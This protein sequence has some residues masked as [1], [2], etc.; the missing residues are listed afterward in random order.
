MNFDAFG[1]RSLKSKVVLVTLCIFAVCVALA[2]T[3]ISARMYTDL[4]GVLGEQQ[5][6]TVEMA[7]ASMD[8]NFK[9]RFGALQSIAKSVD[10]STLDKPTSV[11]KLLEDRP[12]LQSYFNAGVFVTRRDGTAIAELPLIGRVGGNYMDRDHVAA[13]LTQGKATVGKAVVGKAVRA[14][15]FAMTVPIRDTQGKVIGALVGATDLSRPNFMDSVN[16]ARYGLAGGYLVVDPTHRLFVTATNRNLV[17]ASLPVTGINTV[18]DR[19]VQG[20]DGAAVNVNS[21]GVEVLTSSARIPTAG[22][23]L[24]ATLPT[25]EAFAPI[26]AMQRNVLQ[27]M[28]LFAALSCAVL[29]LVLS[30]ML[31][32]QFAQMVDATRSIEALSAKAELPQILP[33]AT[34]DEVGNLI[35]AFNR[36]FSTLRDR[37][38]ELAAKMQELRKLSLAVEQSSSSIVIT[39]LSAEIEYVNA[40]FLRSSGYEKQELIGKNPRI[41]QSGQTPRETYV[42]MWRTL[43][44]GQAWRGEFINRRKNGALYPESVVISPLS[45]SDGRITHYVAVKDDITAAKAA[46]EQI[47]H[48]A[49]IDLLTELPNRRQLIIRLQQELRSAAR[50]SFL[51]ALLFVD[52]DNFKSVNDALGH[53]RADVVLNEV[54]RQLSACVRESDLVARHGADEFVVVLSNLSQDALEATR[55][56]QTVAGKMLATVGQTVLADGTKIHCTSSIGIALFGDRPEEVEEPLRRA[57]LAMFRAKSDGRNTLRFFD[58][59]MQALVTTRISLEAALREA[60]QNKQFALHYQ[61]QVSDSEGIIGAEVLVRWF[62]PK[63]GMVSPAEFIPLAEE[64]GLIVPLGNWV[65]DAACQQLAHWANRP[66]LKHLTLAVNVSA[67]QFGQSNFVD[68]VLSALE[69]TGARSSQLKLEL[70]ESVLVNDVADVSTKMTTL[71]AKGVGFAIDDFGTGYSSLLYLKRLPLERL[72]IDQGFVRDILMDADDAAIARAVIAMAD[73]L[74]LSVVAEGVETQDQCDLLARLGCHIY[75]GYLFSRPL[76]INEFEA[77]AEQF[78]QLVS[79]RG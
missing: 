14:P 77:F 49:Y 56:A 6:A 18:L 43:H 61:A 45:Q 1:F 59:E 3:Y 33:I 54:A 12:L 63:R 16:D 32:R 37:Q 73:S 46:E 5:R 38:S 51:G 17:M 26:A 15:S 48:L 20:F 31:R 9:E 13:A 75:Q 11:Q 69:R 40:G 62:D 25:Q 72:K 65:L 68:Q 42:D 4:Q 23:F 24:I 39:N 10:S 67:R 50:R 74:E 35:G 57:E 76:P 79:S 34:H 19:R 55:Q 47:Q 52:L 66:E 44:Q 21:L 2:A 22:W 30:G 60:I 70:T 71:K 7:S 8:S 78:S 29:W 64:T 28:G 27:A 41:L 53:A 36:L 58:P